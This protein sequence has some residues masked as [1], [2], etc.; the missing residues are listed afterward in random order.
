M[1]T[2][3]LYNSE[4]TYISKDGKLITKEDFYKIYPAAQYVKMVVFLEGNAIS[5]AYTFD[6]LVSHYVISDIF[7]DEQ[8]VQMIEKMKNDEETESTPIERIASALEY[9]AMTMI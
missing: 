3:E 4:K 1:Y 6:Y 2:A 5:E 7:N 9:I 8:K